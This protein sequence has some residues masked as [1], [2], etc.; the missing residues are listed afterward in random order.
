MILLPEIQAII[1][2][3][4]SGSAKVAVQIRMNIWHEDVFA[5]NVSR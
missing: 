5:I 4:I 3:V 1:A 2:M